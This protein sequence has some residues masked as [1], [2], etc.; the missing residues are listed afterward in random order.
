MLAACS[1]TDRF[2]QSRS[3]VDC[4]AVAGAS[5]I[6]VEVLFRAALVL[7]ARYAKRR[8]ELQSVTWRIAPLQEGEADWMIASAVQF[9]ARQLFIDGRGLSKGPIRISC[10][11]KIQK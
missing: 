1:I 4:A 3:C 10:E 9:P 6:G 8:I 7:I 5:G 2:Q 11:R